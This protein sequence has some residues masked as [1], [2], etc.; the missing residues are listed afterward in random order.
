MLLKIC[1]LSNLFLDLLVGLLREH[2]EEVIIR[3]TRDSSGVEIHLCVAEMILLLCFLDE[4][5][6]VAYVYFDH[7][8]DMT[9]LFESC[10]DCILD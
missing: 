9:V 1:C 7:V 10:F 5:V 6:K 8:F 2:V 3:L 4:L